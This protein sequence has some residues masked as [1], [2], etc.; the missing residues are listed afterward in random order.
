M[1]PGGREGEGG[2]R[3][4]EGGLRV[5]EGGVA[6]QE[7]GTWPCLPTCRWPYASTCWS[8]PP[9]RAWSRG[10]G[11]LCNYAAITCSW[12]PPGRYNRQISIMQIH[13]GILLLVLRKVHIISKVPTVTGKHG[14]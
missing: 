3:V 1:Y 5:G 7:G 12:F 9:G 6:T 14:K 11:T 2:L 4:G 13:D 10:I 8:P